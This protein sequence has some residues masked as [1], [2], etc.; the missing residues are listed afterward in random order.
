[1][2]ILKFS[3]IYLLN[4]FKLRIV[5]TIVLSIAAFLLLPGISMTESDN[6]S[7]QIVEGQS[8]GSKDSQGCGYIADRPNHQMNLSQRIDYMRL[9]VQTDGGQPTL[10]VLGPN[11][12][13]SFCVLGDEI[14]GLKPE[15]SGVWEAGNY[16]V[17]IGDRSGDRHR[18]V[19]NIST[20]N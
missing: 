17:Y 13:D 5:N 14:S 12:G 1:M 9:T 6:I 10:L 2:A 11:S 8:G 19:L 20:D 16:D 15:I 3:A 4:P 7:S 18:F